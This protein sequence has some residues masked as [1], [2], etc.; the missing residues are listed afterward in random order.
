MEGGRIIGEGVDG[1]IFTEPSWPCVPGTAQGQA[2]MPNDKGYVA[3]I[4]NNGDIES[5][6]IKAATR[7]LGPQLSMYI[8]GMKSECAPVNSQHPPDQSQQYSFELGKSALSKWAK[9]T[10]SGSCWD[11]QQKLKSNKGISQSHKIMYIS[12]YPMTVIEWI[13][14]HRN[15]KRPIDYAIKDT[16]Q[17]I[18]QLLIV[19]Q[20]LVQNPSEQLIHID[21]HA[22]NIFVKPN[23]NTVNFGIT[24]FGH[25]ILRQAG[26]ASKYTNAMANYL[27]EYILS[28]GEF[29]AR[30]SQIPLEARL[31]DFVYHKNL[32][33]VSPGNI[34]R[35]WLQDPTIIKYK[36]GYDICM[37]DPNVFMNNLLKFPLFIALLEQ[38]Q[39]ISKKTRMYSNDCQKLANSLTQEEKIVLD[40]I[41][42]RYTVISPINSIVE[43]VLTLKRNGAV[44]PQENKLL[45]F[46]IRVIYT[47]YDAAIGSSLTSSLTAVRN[48]DLGI[49]WADVMRST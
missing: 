10:D 46:L 19:L 5:G 4:V 6:Y 45:L 29:Y 49:I 48:G 15:L 12:R 41:L 34:V 20:K 3:K 38:I 16:I 42:T 25:C 2:P 13:E 1:C 7:I 32:D 40:F 21:L 14:K 9:G 39:A 22:N 27:C 44:S 43:A 37:A 35:A 23:N 18:P 24:D 17:A 31:L 33:N 26:D 11:I 36:G 8:A 30:Y 28:A 47:P